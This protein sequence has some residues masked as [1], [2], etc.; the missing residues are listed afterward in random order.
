MVPGKRTRYQDFELCKAIFMQL[1]QYWEPA[2]N[3]GEFLNFSVK[4]FSGVL[5][6]NINLEFSVLVT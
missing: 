5:N 2:V 4:G 6:P 1:K 3:A